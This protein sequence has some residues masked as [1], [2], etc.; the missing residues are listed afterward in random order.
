MIG[1]G[2]ED[3][4]ALGWEIS[5]LFRRYYLEPFFMRGARTYDNRRRKPGREDRTGRE[6]SREEVRGTARGKG[7]RKPEREGNRWEGGQDCDP[8]A[9]SDERLCWRGT[10]QCFAFGGRRTH[11]GG[12]KGKAGDKGR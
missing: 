4:K 1:Q 3:E 5:V 11:F 12:D 7:E 8:G 2:A 6:Q 10:S 9:P